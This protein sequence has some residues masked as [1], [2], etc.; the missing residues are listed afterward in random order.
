MF[1]K[2]RIAMAVATVLSLSMLLSACAPKENAGTTS[3][4]GSDAGN[5]SAAE[6]SVNAAAYPGTADPNSV[7]INMGAEPPE[8]NSI[9]TTDATAISVMRDTMQ[10]LTVLDQSNIPVPGIAEKWTISD[11]SLVYTFNLRKDAKWNNGDPVTA[12][13]FY[14]AISQH[15]TAEN[16]APYAST[17]AAYIKGAEAY[18]NG[19][20]TL[21]D[22]GMKVIDDYTIEFTLARPCT[23]FLSICAFASF[24]PV[25]QKFYETVGA[26]SYGKDADKILTNG[27]YKIESW[28]HEDN[29]VL[30]K[31][32]N[33]W[34]SANYSQVQ[35]INMKMISD[36]NAA[37]NAFQAGEVDMIGLTGANVEILKKEG[38]TPPQFD[39]GT[40]AYIEFNT[41]RE[42]TEGKA[43]AQKEVRQALTLALDVQRYLTNVAKNSNKV[44]NTFTP[45]VVNGANGKYGDALGEVL[46][47]PTGDYTAVKATFE[48]GLKKAGVNAADLKLSIL[49]DE[50][51][52]AQQM[53]AM[54]QQQWK[55]NLGIDVTIVQKPFKGR[56]ADQAT[57]E[58]DMCVALWGPDYSD[59]M[60]Y[61]D[62]FI[63]GAGNNHTGWS[64]KTYDELIDKA[65][66]EA[67]AVVR[68]GYLMEAEKLLLDEMPVGP[69]YHRVRDYICSAKLGGVVRTAFQ[70]ISMRWCTI[71]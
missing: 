20:G 64:N 50:G 37:L 15:F 1:A 58:F 52:S 7:T 38:I 22:V 10:G 48:E 33:F 23:Y 69:I 44:A 51:D 32:T 36:S 9:L 40:P 28:A 17:W 11:D 16:A 14:F 46:K 26:A 31:D 71:N 66:N 29:M 59:A 42:T 55:E 4:A 21:E 24:L 63:T 43:L 34:D 8:L 60:T 3:S 61:L 67:D 70:E 62:M 27:P 6:P 25:N 57:G 13:D 19:K 18:L 41:I 56:L 30:T 12:N 68:E 5:S 39:D 35:T 54:F 2:K 45:N 65:Y 49:S 53:C 47:R